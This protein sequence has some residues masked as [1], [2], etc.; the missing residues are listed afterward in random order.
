[1]PRKTPKSKFQNFTMDT[2]KRSDIKNADYNPR[3]IDGGAQLKLREGLEKHGLVQPIVWNKRT[4]NIVGG[5]QRLE[6]LDT[7]EKGKNYELDVAVVDV[8]AKEE[9]T[10]NVLLNNPSLQGD[11][12]LDKL[13]DIKIDYGI[14]FED[15]GFDE[16]DID[17]LFEGD[18]RFSELFDTPEVEEEKMKIQQVRSSRGQA[19]ERLT[20]EN[21][22]DF[23]SMIV[24][25]SQKE[26]EAFYERICVPI[27]EDVITVE[28]IERYFD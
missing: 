8:D 13:A 16:L 22:A 7:L 11:W 9:A 6:Q 4:G 24:F 17:F 18:D 5:H 23:Y 28:E 27:Y 1:M 20:E 25:E 10:I 26:K 21:K 14:D 19:K 12:D 2:V 3:K 15:M